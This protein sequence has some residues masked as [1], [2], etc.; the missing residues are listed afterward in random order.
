MIVA[1]DTDVLIDLLRGRS[2]QVRARMS[3]LHE[4]GDE[5]VM[6]SIVLYELT[7]AALRSARPELHLNE[8]DALVERIEVV[9]LSGDDALTAARVQV[10]LERAGQGIG[11]FDRLIAGQAFARDWSLVT[12]NLWE[13]ARVEGLRLLDWSNPDEVVSITGGLS[14]FRPPP[15]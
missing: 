13:F 6:S 5:L 4:R 8:I 1:L 11:V 15:R 10:E 3:E 12:G 14:W 9:S 7:R 2:P